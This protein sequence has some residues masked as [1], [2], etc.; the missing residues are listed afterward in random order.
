MLLLFAVGG[1]A[2]V[3]QRWHAIAA[4]F[5]LTV[6]AGAGLFHASAVLL[7]WGAARRL[8]LGRED[9]FTLGIEV[10]VQN[11]VIGLLVAELLGRR[12]LVPLIGCYMLVTVVLVLPWVRLLGPAAAAE[13][14]PPGVAPPPDCLP[15]GSSSRRPPVVPLGII[16]GRR[17]APWP[18]ASKDEYVRQGRGELVGRLPHGKDVQHRVHEEE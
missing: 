9:S 4:S 6:L 5:S 1:A 13:S 18:R 8:G 10:G 7:A 3:A 15:Q 2:Y 11:F 17:L 12:E 14:A 16:R